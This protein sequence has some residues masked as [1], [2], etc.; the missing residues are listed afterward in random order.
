MKR[1]R[2]TMDA[3]NML[4]PC[5][6][7]SGRWRQPSSGAANCRPIVSLRTCGGASTS[8]CSARHSATRTAVLSGAT[9]RSLISVLQFGP[10]E[11]H[12][13]VDV[14]RRQAAGVHEEDLRIRLEIA[15]A[16]QADQPGHD[17]A[18]VNRI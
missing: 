14:Q 11:D 17:L 2:A 5:G 18:G 3:R 10:S 1:A 8:T 12:V 4:V 13:L 16:R 7:M 6:C 15:L 9:V